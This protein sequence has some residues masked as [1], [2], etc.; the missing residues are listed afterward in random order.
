MIICM[1]FTG[2]SKNS[3]KFS[4]QY[5]RTYRNLDDISSVTA[6]NSPEKLQDYCIYIEQNGGNISSTNADGMSFEG[7]IQKYDD[8]F[9]EKKLLAVVFLKEGSGSIKHKVTSVVKNT[10]KIDINIKRKSPQTVNAMVAYWYIIIELEKE[11]VPD[12]AV[13]SLN[14]K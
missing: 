14:V 4:V 2:C 5:I 11:N 6:V 3:L 7:A 9:F 10:E 12:N 1:V 8:D 13:F